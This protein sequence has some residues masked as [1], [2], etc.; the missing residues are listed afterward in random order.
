MI[1]ADRH[2]RPALIAAH[3]RLERVEERRQFVLG[4]EFVP[5]ILFVIVGALRVVVVRC[6]HGLAETVVRRGFFLEEAGRGLFGGG[7]G[8]GG[9]FEFGG[10]FRAQFF[11]LGFRGGGGGV[12]E[13][14]VALRG[15]A[16]EPG[17]GEQVFRLR[18]KRDDLPLVFAEIV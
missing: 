5:L 2:A 14:P 17:E 7:C 15:A 1:D 10:E 3:V 11:G 9:G 8:G 16:G 12:L 6:V 13:R 4:G 18:L